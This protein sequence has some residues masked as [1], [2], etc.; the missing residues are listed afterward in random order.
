MS[1]IVDAGKR[2]LASCGFR[3]SRLQ[4]PG[5]ILRPIGDLTGCLEDAR[6]R[7]FDPRM[8]FDVGASDGSWTRTARGVFPDAA[9]VLVEARAAARRHLEQMAHGDPRC[10]IVPA[11]AGRTVGKGVLTEADTAS[12]LLPVDWNMPTTTVPVTT[13]D[14]LAARHGWPDLVK[15][16]VEGFELEVLEGASSL[17]GR[18]ELFIVETALFGFGAPRPEIGD[19]CE[20]MKAHGYVPYDIAGFIRRPFDGAL[21]LVDVCFARRDGVL[22]RD[23]ASWFSAR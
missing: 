15:L 23:S 13:L 16:D 3:L 14:A 12:T 11:A 7:A 19:V 2:L 4:P 20:F 5:S 8:V 10:T 1:A 9:F 17:F 6:A 21:A 22:R 18:T